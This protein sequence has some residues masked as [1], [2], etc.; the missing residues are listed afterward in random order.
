MDSFDRDLVAV[1]QQEGR[2]ANVQLAERVHL[3]ESACLRRVRTLESQGVIQGYSA[4]VDPQKVGL[5][6]IVFVSITLE[7]QDQDELRVF[8]EAVRALP[9]VMDCY[10]MTGEFDYLLRVVVADTEDFERI[11][12]QQLTRLPGVARV[13][14]S[15]ALRTVQKSAALPIRQLD[16]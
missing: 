6:G 15:F 4:R 3:S 9:E 8:E 16:P 7:R 13:H 12:S 1:L 11:H 5:S 10:L 14:S 2:I